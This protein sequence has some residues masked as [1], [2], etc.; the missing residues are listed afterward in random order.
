MYSILDIKNTEKST[1]KEHNW[2]IKYGEFYDALFN[3]KV[4]RHTMRE[5]TLKN[6]NLITYESNKKST[7]CF[8]DKRYIQENGI[9]TLAYGHKIIVNKIT[10]N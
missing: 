3:K 6:H 4:L 1:H 9:D 5:I 10:I 8:D 2:Y 7:S